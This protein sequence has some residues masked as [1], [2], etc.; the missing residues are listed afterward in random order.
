MYLCRMPLHLSHANIKEGAFL[1]LEI[2]KL[3]M[4]ENFD[5]CLNLTEMDAW[6]KFS[7]VIKNLFGNLFIRFGNLFI[8]IKTTNRMLKKD[9]EEG[10]LLHMHLDYFPE[11]LQD[12]RKEHRERFYLD[13]KGDGKCIKGGGTL[14]C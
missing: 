12:M 9:A 7:N 5:K 8:R 1:D 6:I 14:V 11:N 3:M 13:K 10:N 4:D 2:R